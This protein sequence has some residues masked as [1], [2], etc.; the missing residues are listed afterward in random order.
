M[1]VVGKVAIVTGANCGIG[2]RAAELLCEAGAEVILACRSEARG[3]DAVGKIRSANESAKASF[4]QVRC[5]RRFLPLHS[6]FFLEVMVSANRD[7]EEFTF[8]RPRENVKFSRFFRNSVA[9]TATTEFSVVYRR[10]NQHQD[11]YIDNDFH[12]CHL[13]AK[14][15]QPWMNQMFF[16]FP[17][18]GTT[19]THPFKTP[20]TR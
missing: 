9:L 2:F 11:H 20:S 4:M 6:S 7:G 10:V 5:L 16:S 14:T 12:K 18:M 1:S 17:W 19:R 8:S 3:N 13:D 15:L